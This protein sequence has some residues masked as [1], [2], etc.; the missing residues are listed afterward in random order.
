MRL[1]VLGGS[2]V[3]VLCS[4]VVVCGM[5]VVCFMHRVMVLVVLGSAVGRV[6]AMVT[7]AAFSLAATNYTSTPRCLWQGCNVCEIHVAKVEATVYIRVPEQ[8]TSR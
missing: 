5:V 8:L 3:V 4:M 2:G 7:V 1:V 6:I